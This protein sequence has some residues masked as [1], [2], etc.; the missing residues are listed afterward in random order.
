MKVLDIVGSSESGYVD[1]DGEVVRRV[2]G[3]VCKKIALKR[4]GKIED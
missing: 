1:G 3:A 4:F 2:D